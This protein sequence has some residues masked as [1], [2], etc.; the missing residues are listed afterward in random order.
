MKFHRTPRLSL[1]I[2]TYRRGSS[3]VK[4]IKQVLSLKRKPDQI[5]VLDQTETHITDTELKL[6]AMQKKGDIVWKRLSAPS[7]P[8]AM[9]IA[10]IESDCDLVL[11]LDDDIEITSEVVNEHIEGHEKSNAVVVVGKITQ[12]WHL[13]DLENPQY[14]QNFSFTSD[15]SGYINSA[16]AGNMSVNRTKAIEIGG[17][18]E[19]FVRVAYRFE[20]EFAQRV[21]SVGGRIYYYPAASIS[22]LKINEGGTRTFGN[23]LTTIKPHHSVGAYYFFLRAPKIKHRIWNVTIRLMTSSLTRHHL[24]KPWWIPIT[25]ISELCGMVW[26]MRLYMK[27]PR[28][29]NTQRRLC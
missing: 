27:G 10:L 2:P 12:P 19:N 11:F 18:D 26:A 16:M 7:I 21:T 25:V 14:K 4:T 1:A 23:H 28:Y 8:R 6:S 20:D 17:F 3:L 24:K 9:N 22:H 5:L 29:I 13:Q 15:I